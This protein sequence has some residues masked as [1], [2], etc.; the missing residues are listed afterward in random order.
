MS[1]FF[2][3]LGP[4]IRQNRKLSP[5]SNLE[6]HNLVMDLLQIKTVHRAANNVR[7]SLFNAPLFSLSLY[8]FLCKLSL[9]SLIDLAGHIGLLG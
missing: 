7:L 8:L 2:L 3:A 1:A 4:A 6:V 9:T 5:F